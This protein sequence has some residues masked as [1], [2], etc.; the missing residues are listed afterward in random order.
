MTKKI[1]VYL[2]NRKRKVSNSKIDSWNVNLDGG[3]LEL[4]GQSHM[5]I[6][7]AEKSCSHRLVLCPVI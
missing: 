2:S 3:R 5:P 7:R 1:N 4:E 6:Y